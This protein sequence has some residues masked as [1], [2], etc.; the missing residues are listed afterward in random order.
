MKWT[1]GEHKLNRIS[2]TMAY[3]ILFVATDQQREL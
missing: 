1:L 3:T 2:E